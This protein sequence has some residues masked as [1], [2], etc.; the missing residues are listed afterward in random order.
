MFC[1]KL[2]GGQLAKRR[3]ARKSFEH[4]GERRNG[5]LNFRAFA[6]V[7]RFPEVPDGVPV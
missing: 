3:N 1:R 5:A 4:A 7:L 2:S 6:V